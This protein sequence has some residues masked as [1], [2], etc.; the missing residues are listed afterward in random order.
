MECWEEGLRCRGVRRMMRGELAHLQG[1]TRVI[2]LVALVITVD[3]SEIDVLRVRPLLPDPARLSLG[4]ITPPNPNPAGLACAFHYT[5]GTHGPGKRLSNLARNEF[6]KCRASSGWKRVSVLYVN[7][8]VIVPEMLI[9]RRWEGFAGILRRTLREIC[10][11]TS[12][13]R[14]I[15]F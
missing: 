6:C 12:G 9:S 15:F 10:R 13:E 1:F 4:A 8:S 3:V 5:N 7:E 14:K 2:D 11:V